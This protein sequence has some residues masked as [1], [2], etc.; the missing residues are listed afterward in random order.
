MDSTEKLS[1]K[2]I[3]N[4]TKGAIL[5]IGGD[6]Y[7]I[8]S[9]NNRKWHYKHRGYDKSVFTGPYSGS[10]PAY[11]TPPTEE[12]IGWADEILAGVS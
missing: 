9:C 1:S 10:E 8:L 5:D 4:Y 3:N 11:I 6:R 2:D 7:L 12:S